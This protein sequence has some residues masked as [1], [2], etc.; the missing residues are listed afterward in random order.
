MFLKKYDLK[1]TAHISYKEM[2][3]VTQTGKTGYAGAHCTVYSTSYT[4]GRNAFYQYKIEVPR[5]QNRAWL[6]DILPFSEIHDIQVEQTEWGIV[7]EMLSTCDCGVLML[8]DGGDIDGL[9][10]L[11]ECIDDIIVLEPYPI[12]YAA[13]AA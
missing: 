2:S 7:I 9:E 8:T 6:E 11:A 5:A 3:G 1:N 10:A 12:L 4:I 13:S